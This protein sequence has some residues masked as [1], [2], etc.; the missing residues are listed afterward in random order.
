MEK[1]EDNKQFLEKFN[2]EQL[3]DLCKFYKRQ[4][5]PLDYKDRVVLG[6]SNPDIIK[7]RFA[8]LIANFFS[9]SEIKEFAQKHHIK[10]D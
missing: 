2:L 1:K 10:I 7:R 5:H 9:Q 8:S 4:L 3:H 6:E